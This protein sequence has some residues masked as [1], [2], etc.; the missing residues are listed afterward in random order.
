MKNRFGEQ[1]L[2]HLQ[3]ILRHCLLL[4]RGDPGNLGSGG[5]KVCAIDVN[6]HATAFHQIPGVG[7]NG[8]ENGQRPAKIVQGFQR[9]THAN[10]NRI[11]CRFGVWFL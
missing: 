6:A 2:K 10:S 9:Q 1:F 8:I 7:L 3:G 4:G 11:L 5:C